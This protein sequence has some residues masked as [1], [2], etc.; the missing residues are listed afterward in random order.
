MGL[1]FWNAAVLTSIPS[2]LAIFWEKMFNKGKESSQ[3]YGI[4]V[5]SF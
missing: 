5:R 4:G 2:I 1:L 3:K